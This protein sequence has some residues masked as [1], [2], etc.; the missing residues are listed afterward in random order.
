[1]IPRNIEKNDLG[2]IVNL[3]CRKAPTG[4]AVCSSNRVVSSRARSPATL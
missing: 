2:F 3:M 4:E 1:M